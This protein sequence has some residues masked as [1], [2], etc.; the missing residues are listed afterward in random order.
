MRWNAKLIAGILIVLAALYYWLVV[1]R[2]AMSSTP[3]LYIFTFRMFRFADVLWT[4]AGI[5]L[6]YRGYVEGREES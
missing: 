1:R 4:I 6:L 5:T 2:A 3:L